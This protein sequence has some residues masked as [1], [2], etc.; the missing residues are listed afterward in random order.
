MTKEKKLEIVPLWE[1]KL[2]TLEEAAAYTGVG[3]NRLRRLTELPACEFVIWI[4]G[5][6][7]VKRVKLEDY[8]EKAYSI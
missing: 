6:R 1:R 5:R 2:L 8:L 7:M 3:I 4:G